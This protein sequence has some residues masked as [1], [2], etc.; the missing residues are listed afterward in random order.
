MERIIKQLVFLS[1]LPRSG[2]TLLSSILSEN[3]LIHAEGNSAVCQ[4]MWDMSV[5]CEI[6][7]R[8]QLAANNRF[9]TQQYL[10][11]EIPKIYYQNIDRPIVIDKCRSWTL[12]KN[13]NL[14]KQYI[15]PDPKI[16]VLTR[17]I[18][19]IVQSFIR[20]GKEN[21]K[22]FNSKELLSPGSEPIMRSLNGVDWAKKNNSGEFLFIDYSDLV[23]YTNEVI[24]SIYSFCGWDHFKH[25]LS[26]IVNRFPEND[27]VYGMRG[28]HEV[29]L[30]P[31]FRDAG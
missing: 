3:P 7:S 22:V 20:L 14:I 1:G 26:N 13:I 27:D 17:P 31:C 6:N 23:S 9:E 29:R 8:E 25:D 16:I 21:S 18:D 19:E 5:S 28:M 24:A 10:I 15:C 30:T 4:L 11:S 12:E 2:S